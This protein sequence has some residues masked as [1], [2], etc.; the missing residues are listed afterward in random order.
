MAIMRELDLLEHIYSTNRV[1]PDH[2]LIGP[3]DDT[4]VLRLAGSDVLVTV[5]QLADGVHV[6][7]ATTALEKIARKAI[8]RSLSDVAAMAA[9][10]T[11]AVVAAS[12]PRQFG[13]QRTR[14]LFDE[15]R[16]VAMSFGCPLV[17]GDISIWDHPLLLGVTILAQP[18]VG[19]G[20]VTRSGAQEGDIVCVTGSLGG[21]RLT[22]DGYSHH[23]DFEPRLKI[24]RELAAN[25]HLTI[26]AMIDLSDGLAMDLARL[27]SAGASDLAAEIWVDRLPIS[28]A[29]HKA[30][31]KDGCPSWH[32]AMG[33]GE[34]Y[35][36]CFLVPA[37]QAESVLP[38]V[39]D[40]VSVTQVGVVTARCGEATV[41]L[42]MPDGSIRPADQLGWEHKGSDL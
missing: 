23:L 6:D 40:G 39:V 36:L 14:Q 4:A 22:I 10:P 21:S 2:V 25:P 5:D 19:H 20:P 34:D 1:L 8:T 29:A 41:T 16:S 24:A 17:G 42:K 18:A 33:D 30:S 28:A 35:E 38:A 26:R 27:C 11:A 3:G 32:H 9:I 31:Q 12:V 15:M 7:L 13:D 37:S